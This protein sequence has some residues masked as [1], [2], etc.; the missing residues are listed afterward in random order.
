MKCNDPLLIPIFNMNQYGLHYKWLCLKNLNSSLKM[1]F[2]LPLNFYNS[3]RISLKLMKYVHS[4]IEWLWDEDL[5]SIALCSGLVKQ[6]SHSNFL[7]NYN[8]QCSL[9]YIL[10]NHNLT[11]SLFQLD[12]FYSIWSLLLAFKIYIILKISRTQS[13][14]F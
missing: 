10:I 5:V 8:Y 11:I 7:S 1:F 12:I 13:S 3:F 6:I 14:Y 4:G 9:P 2:I